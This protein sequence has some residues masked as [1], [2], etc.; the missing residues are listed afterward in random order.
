MHIYYVLYMYIYSYISFKE[1]FCGGILFIKI[2]KRKMP[3]LRLFFNSI[4]FQFWIVLVNLT[5]SLID[6]SLHPK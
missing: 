6:A 4:T 5:H 2:A 1:E 3:L